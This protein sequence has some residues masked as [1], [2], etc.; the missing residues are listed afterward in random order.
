[1][2]ECTYVCVYVYMCVCA[3]LIM[4]IQ[5]RDYPSSLFGGCNVSVSG[6]LLVAEQ[7]ARERGTYVRMYMYLH[8]LHDFYL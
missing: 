1:M 7:E 2:Y 5:L 4:Q 8:S 3:C 6:R